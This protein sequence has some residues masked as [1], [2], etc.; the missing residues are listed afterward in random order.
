[1]NDLAIRSIDT[2]DGSIVVEME[3][4]DGVKLELR[5]SSMDAQS[6]IGAL[7]MKV[8]EIT[9]LP[10]VESRSSVDTHHIQLLENGE[11]LL[12]RVFLR[13]GLFHEY[14]VAS[15]TTLADG[16]RRFFSYEASRQEAKQTG[17][18]SGGNH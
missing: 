16:L 18:S 5:L 17:Q 2:K 6:L 1:M 8:S 9:E 3:Q 7:V 13:Q 15:N 4:G 14:K 10:L 12:F 11:T